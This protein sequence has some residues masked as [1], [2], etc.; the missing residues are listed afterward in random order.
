M[1]LFLKQGV[2]IEIEIK[3]ALCKKGMN[4]KYSACFDW[5]WL[6]KQKQTK[7]GRIQ[8]LPSEFIGSSHVFSRPQLPPKKLRYSPVF[9]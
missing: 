9:S 4:L 5:S 1:E 7:L 6:A 8:L 2:N 3:A